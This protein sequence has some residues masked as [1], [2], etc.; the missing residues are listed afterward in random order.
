MTKLAKSNQ[1]YERR[2]IVSYMGKVG[3]FR[4][5]GRKFIIWKYMTFYCGEGKQPIAAEFVR[6]ADKDEQGFLRIEGL[7]PGEIAVT[8]GLIYR[9]VPM[10][11]LMMAEHLRKMKNFKPRDLVIYEKDTTS[12]A[13]DLGTIDLTG[14]TKQ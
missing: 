7:K 5:D 4:M 6:M 13:E 8:P 12:P 14:A 1:L 2:Q 10:S 9:K 11:G 3:H